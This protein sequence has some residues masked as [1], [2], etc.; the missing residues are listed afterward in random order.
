MEANA[1]AGVE[2]AQ[3]SRRRCERGRQRF[4]SLAGAPIE[5]SWRG[6]MG[7]RAGSR[8]CVARILPIQK[9]RAAFRGIVEL[10][11]AT[12]HD[13]ATFFALDTAVLVI[14]AMPMIEV[15]NAPRRMRSATPRRRGGS[16]RTKAASTI[17]PTAGCC[18]PSNLAIS[19]CT[20]GE[21]QNFQ[22]AL[23]RRSPAHWLRAAVDQLAATTA[24][25]VAAKTS[26][27]IAPSSS[28]TAMAR[29][30]NWS[31]LAGLIDP[32]RAQPRRAATCRR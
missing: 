26:G 29:S 24:S 28:A 18:A 15:S 32:A 3:R 12:A 31:G 16:S 19:R 5:A 13:V 27:V 22:V 11:Y 10:R 25:F 1:A 9:R 4:R 17:T 2:F 6:A 30:S 23:P 8:R 20:L 7:S 21:H 14:A